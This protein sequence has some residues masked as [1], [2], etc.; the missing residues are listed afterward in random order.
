MNKHY[1]PI[2]YVVGTKPNGNFRDL[3]GEE[4]A[5]IIY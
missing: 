5:G 3:A 1:H 4:Q 2:A